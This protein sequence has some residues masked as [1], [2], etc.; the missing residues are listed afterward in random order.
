MHFDVRVLEQG[1]VRR[2]RLE[3]ASADALAAQLNAQGRLPLSLRASRPTTIGAG[4]F[5][6]ALFLQELCSLLQAG[7]GV[8]EAL[9]VELRKARR[10][11]ERQVLQQLNAA[12]QSGAS[13][14]MAL[15]EQSEHFDPLLVAS[16]RASETSG[17]LLPALQRYLDYRAQVHRVQSAVVSA[18][19]YPLTLLGVGLL[20]L[21]FLLLFV[22][23]RFAQIFSDLGRAL[24]LFSR[25]LMQLGGFVEA[26]RLSL[27][28]LLGFGVALLVWALFTPSRRQKSLQ[29]LWR[30]PG[31]G[32][33]LDQFA[34]AR[35]FRMIAL[36]LDSGLPLLQSCRLLQ[37]M[38][39][40]TL[41]AKLKRAAQAVAAGHTFSQALHAQNLVCPVADSLLGAGERGGNL[42][43]ALHRVADHYDADN[44]RWLD[45]FMR[46][47]E[48]LL[49]LLLGL[50]I[51][52]VVVMM[53]MPVF[54]LAGALQ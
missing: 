22:L 12:L 20:V 24:P 10:A 40:P 30:L 1:Q 19:L 3:A 26:H 39:N 51:G 50:L 2:L 42:A 37:G 33:R 14:S 21:T 8:V 9:Q 13:L 54:E 53:Y 38:L 34:R 4:R 18:L 49:M 25:L 15:S 28:G 5:D 27:L 6:S 11:G 16:V 41:D 35:L 29:V 52:G 48:P 43:Q 44:T 36:L 17:T 23:P 7:I 46:L 47:F 32:A 31:L 45:R